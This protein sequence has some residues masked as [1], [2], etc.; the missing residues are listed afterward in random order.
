[1][2]GRRVVEIG[3]QAMWDAGG[4][5]SSM[6]T[7]NFG[8][9]PA[10]NPLLADITLNSPIKEGDVAT[11]TAHAHYH[12]YAGHSDQEIV[13]GNPKQRHL[14]MFD[15]VK[16]VR[17]GVLKE[18]RAGLTNR[19]LNDCYRAC[20]ASTGFLSS[21]HSQMHQYGLD[22]PEFPGPAFAVPDPGK[23]PL[24]SGSFM[25]ATGMVFSISP[26]LC[27]EETGE[28]LLG[29]TSLVVSEGGYRE[30]G[31]RPVDILVAGS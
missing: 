5:P 30:L 21:E 12:H 13:F 11:L 10:Q 18:V 19:E 25:L 17:D 15:A 26:T 4:D 9:R 3:R 20:C 31:A 23:K 1:M 22:V 27:D 16:K 8:A 29:G 24:P 14:K 7:L 6:F 28:L 2:L